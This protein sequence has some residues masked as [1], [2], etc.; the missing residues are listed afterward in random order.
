M[1][2]KHHDK[3]NRRREIEKKFI[4]SASLYFVMIFRF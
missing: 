3:M 4:V 1:L 2:E